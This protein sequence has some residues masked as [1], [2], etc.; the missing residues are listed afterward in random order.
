LRGNAQL[1]TRQVVL[2]C[3]CATVLHSCSRTGHCGG[4]RRN[5]WCIQLGLRKSV[6]DRTGCRGSRFC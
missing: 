1:A 3:G 2:C 4:Q 6:R 5:C